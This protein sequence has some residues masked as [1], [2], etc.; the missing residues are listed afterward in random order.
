MYTNVVLS[1]LAPFF[2]QAHAI[3]VTSPA[4][5][6]FNMAKREVLDALTA[7]AVANVRYY[8]IDT[9]LLSLEKKSWLRVNRWSPL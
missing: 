5:T 4:Y 7:D 1:Q 2:R 8:D 6:N 9:G 3:G